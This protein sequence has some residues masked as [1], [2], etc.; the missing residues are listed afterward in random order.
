M[1]VAAGLVAVL[2]VFLWGL[3]VSG[4]LLFDYYRIRPW[5]LHPGIF[6]VAGCV[7]LAAACGLGIRKPLVKW[8]GVVLIVLIG[9]VWGGIVWFASLLG[10]TRDEVK[11]LPS[12]DGSMELV[13]LEGGGL[14]IDTLTSVR[15]F[16]N[17]G[18]LSRENSLGC[19]NGERDGLK[20]VEWTGPRT[21][22]VELSRAGTTTITL[23]DGGRPDHTINGGC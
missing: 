10:G 3:V 9:V 7:A 19:I 16:T 4:F 5:L 11:R 18:L 13:V 1:R 17:H 12:P 14:S 15:V 22:R 21:V 2:G 20:D 8:L 6:G 23:D